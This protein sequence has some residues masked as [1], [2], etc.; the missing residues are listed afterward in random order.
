M[1]DINCPH[2]DVC[3]GCSRDRQVERP[4]EYEK[5]LHFFESKGI[6]SLQ[7]QVGNP[8]GWRCRAKLAIRG[9][10]AVPLIGLFEEGSHRVINIP[11]CKV[12]HPSI[13]K[14]ADALRRWI[15]EQGIV[16]YDENAG[17]GLL[18]YVQMAVE[19]ASGRVQVALVINQDDK[20]SN[21][22]SQLVALWQMH[23]DLWHSLWLNCNTRRDN[24][25]FGSVWHHLYGKLWL[26]ESFLGQEV[27][28]HPASF[29]Q[30]NL[31]MFERLL[32][33]VLQLL[34]QDADVL[35][36]YAGI[37]AIGFAIAQKC[38]RIH[39]IEINP[40][41]KL[42]FEETKSRLP[43][44]L[45]S[46]LIFTSGKAAASL[47]LLDHMCRKSGVVIVDPPRKGLESVLLETLCKRD[48][49]ERLFYIS[50]GWNSFQ[51]DCMRLLEAGWRLI[52][53]EAFLFFPGSDQIEMLCLFQR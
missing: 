2:F 32:E 29:A 40:L 41:A 9:T 44:D 23:P 12:H 43:S 24:I 11:Q 51:R 39:C 8:I 20:D 22:R 21:F 53:A 36:F 27:C 1:A 31:E 4:A 19:R 45:A 50:C 15:L 37:G 48:A 10:S 35:E 3:S 52:H 7:L 16:P 25:I 17:E 28:F 34:P 42:C 33:R 26:Q 13:N 18:R 38:S 49:V 14:A 46:R 47:A 30:A 6:A 5:A